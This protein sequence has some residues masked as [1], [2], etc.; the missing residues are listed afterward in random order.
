MK[1]SC[2]N[3]GGGELG[4]HSM[5]LAD[6][7]PLCQRKEFLLR[8]QGQGVGVRGVCSWNSLEMLMTW[9]GVQ[10]NILPVCL[11]ASV[12]L[13]NSTVNISDVL[14]PSLSPLQ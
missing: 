14:N 11:P 1:R 3:R 12:A 9:P 7:D 13:P 4:F 5:H 8:A 6:E 2:L 10:A